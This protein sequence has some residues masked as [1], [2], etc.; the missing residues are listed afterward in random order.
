M[1]APLFGGRRARAAPPAPTV[2]RRLEGRV[3][4]VTGAAAGIGRGIAEMCAEEGAT[5]ILGDV[6]L[7][8]AEAA[9]EALAARGL[10]AMAV[11][12]DAGDED[13]WRKALEEVVRR[14]GRLDI[15][16]NNAASGWAASLDETSV[17]DWRRIERVTSQGVFIGTK[18]A[19]GAM[20]DRGAIVNVAS[21]AGLKGSASSIAYGAAKSAVI[22]FTRSA[23][24]HCAKTGAQIRVNAVA[25][26]LIR[27]EGLDGV[28]RKFTGGNA[29]LA[30]V[31]REQMRKAV[32]LGFLGEPSDIAHAVVFLAS[33]AAR[34]VTGQTLVV[35]GGM[36][37]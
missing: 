3:C 5:V 27:T 16:V 14:Y 11:A 15:L 4:L 32:P 23:A 17:E 35:D 34:Y 29:L 37:A 33:D 12:H 24:A 2:S 30:P 6:D 18:L 22:G 20:G 36:L 19:I 8:A 9:R 13:A 26:G 1:K 31:V 7:P 25:P 10:A 21:I 28:V